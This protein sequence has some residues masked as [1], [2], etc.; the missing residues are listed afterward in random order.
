MG[1]AH[2]LAVG[3][4]V[5]NSWI[6]SY[7]DAKLKAGLAEAG[8]FSPTDVASGEDAYDAGLRARQDRIA[9]I[10]ADDPDFAAKHKQVMDDFAPTMSGLESQRARGTSQMV[11]LPGGRRIEQD[12]AFTPE[13]MA[14]LRAEQASKVYS[15]QGYPEEAAKSTTVAQGITKNRMD[16]QRGDLELKALQR[17]DKKESAW[18]T[19]DDKYFSLMDPDLP[20]DQK[21]KNVEYLAKQVGP[22]ITANDDRLKGIKYKGVENDP[23]NGMHI[24]VETP[25]GT[26][27]VPLTLDMIHQGYS[28]LVQSRDPA[29]YAEFK[30]K[31]LE[32]EQ[33]QAGL[34]K[35]AEANNKTQLQLGREQNLSSEK[36]AGIR[37]ASMRDRGGSGG[38]P[39]LTP[40]LNEQRMK[41]LQAIEDH[42][43]MT[44]AEKDDAFN[45]VQ[46][47]YNAKA[48][49]LREPS[50]PGLSITD[51]SKIQDM[52]ELRA[53]RDTSVSELRDAA[54]RIQQGAGDQL[55]GPAQGQATSS[56][57]PAP[58]TVRNGF[59]FVGGNPNDRASWERI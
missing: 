25:D 42:P 2:G 32:F 8:N 16:M 53:T 13:Q 1:F 14:G 37:A 10:S 7:R 28:M 29:K 38:I 40:E 56:T 15:E 44:P 19:Q 39:G 20:M 26:G 31:R 18:A 17:Q 52:V 24:L 30:Q 50:K 41:E 51:L 22:I 45:R 46:M 23:K 47:K 35:R 59:R 27:K 34:D 58:G 55:Y 6:N 11:Q 57:G 43:T 4:Q 49:Q 36:V 48:A 5:G 33:T 12:T 21:E 3:T 54:N 9:Q